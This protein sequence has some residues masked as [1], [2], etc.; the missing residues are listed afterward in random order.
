MMGTCCLDQ[1][2]R[3]GNSFRHC[4]S[5]FYESY[6]CWAEVMMGSYLSYEGGVI[7]VF[8]V[9]GEDGFSKLDL[10]GDDEADA[11]GWPFDDGVVLM[12]LSKRKGTLRSS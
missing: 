2:V 9:F 3:D 10:M 1:S 7:G 6:T 8:E 4:V 5:E 12:I 11:V